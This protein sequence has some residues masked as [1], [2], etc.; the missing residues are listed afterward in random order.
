MLLDSRD[1]E[2]PLSLSYHPHAAEDMAVE[3]QNP[4]EDVFGTEDVPDTV[5]SDPQS[6]PSRQSHAQGEHS[7]IPRIRSIHVTNGYREGIAESKSTFVQ[8]GFDEGY[9]LGAM[10]GFRA[11]WLVSFLD[12][13]TRLLNRPD[14]QALA[15]EARKEL[16][17]E[18]ILSPSYFNEDGIWSYNVPGPESEQDFDLVSRSHPLIDKW[19]TR[20]QDLA[21]SAGVEIELFSTRYEDGS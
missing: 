6:S 4:L 13:F 8:E 5:I 7:E 11:A 15:E 3:Y 2:H 20:V 10:L 18:S 9:P 16:Q 19:S 17:I 21:N 1:Y 12:N 14:K